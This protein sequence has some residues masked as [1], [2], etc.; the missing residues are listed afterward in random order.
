MPR[1]LASKRDD[2]EWSDR[3]GFGEMNANFNGGKYIDDKG[4][5]RILNP[6]HPSSIK[7]YVYEHRALFE[8]FLGRYLTSWESVHHINEIKSDNRLENLY[9]CSMSEHSAVHREGKRPSEAHRNKL[10]ENMNNRPKTIRKP[11]KKRTTLVRKN[12]PMDS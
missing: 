12:N 5:V 11:L 10:R 9:L 6:E 4:Y 7:G 8:W 2:V 3:V 1:P